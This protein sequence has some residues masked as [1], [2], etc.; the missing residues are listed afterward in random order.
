MWSFGERPPNCYCFSR[1]FGGVL[2]CGEELGRALFG[3][4]AD[5]K[6]G[7]PGPNSGRSRS[8]KPGVPRS[9][10]RLDGVV[11]LQEQGLTCRVFE[12]PLPQIKFSGERRAKRC[13]TKRRKHKKESTRAL[14]PDVDELG[15]ETRPQEGL[16]WYDVAEVQSREWLRLSKVGTICLGIVARIVRCAKYSVDGTKISRDSEEVTL[17]VELCVE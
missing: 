15:S 17:G 9:K 2:G 3:R 7:S 14:E 12:P 4:R 8:R 13:D 10:R 11:H 6:S 5:G 16:A 1:I